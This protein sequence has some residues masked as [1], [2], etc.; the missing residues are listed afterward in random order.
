LVDIAGTARNVEHFPIFQMAA[1]NILFMSVCHICR[2]QQ[3]IRSCKIDG[4]CL[5]GL[6]IAA[7]FDNQDGGCCHIDFMK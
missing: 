7:V 2:A 3:Y 5:N 6:K 1:A 4:T